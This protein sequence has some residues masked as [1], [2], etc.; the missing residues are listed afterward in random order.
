MTWKS[1]EEK[2]PPPSYFAMIVAHLQGAY[3]GAQISREVMLALRPYFIEAWRNGR[4][5]EAAAQTTCSCDGKNIIP[6]P[7]VDVHIAKRAV[8]PPKG[9][10][11]GDVFGAEGLRPPPAVERMQRRW[12][13]L[14][15][16]AQKQ[17]TVELRWSQRVRVARVE[18]RKSEA[19]RKRAMAMSRR[20]KLLEEAKRIEAEIHRLQIALSRPQPKT[21]SSIP[22]SPPAPLLPAHPPAPDA[23]NRS[24]VPSEAKSATKHPRRKSPDA[25]QRSSASTEA[26]S[27]AMLRAVQGMLPELAKKLAADLHKEGEKK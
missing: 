3:R 10:E 18:T 17:Q 26:Q 23:P 27:A 2:L 21:S 14:T 25:A 24:L 9:I 7:V 4:S 11:R 13:Q 20:D 1:R 15:R 12:E 16:A 22:P 8:R 19:E 5:A 6:S